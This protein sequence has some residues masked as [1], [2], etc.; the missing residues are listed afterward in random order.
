M[1]RAIVAFAV[2]LA[3]AGGI[4]A[5][6]LTL[7]ADAQDQTDVRLATIEAR[8][9]T[10]DVRQTIQSDNIGQLIVEGFPPPNPD[11]SFYAGVV[12]WDDGYASEELCYIRRSSEVLRESWVLTCERFGNGRIG[13]IP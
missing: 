9:A 2:V 1:T 8:L 6:T 13:S 4:V 10:I 11:T 5:A 3:F 12:P 7:P